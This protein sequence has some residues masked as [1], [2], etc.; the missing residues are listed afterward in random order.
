M[1]FISNQSLRLFNYTVPSFYWRE[2]PQNG[3]KE[4]N[5]TEIHLTT[6]SNRVAC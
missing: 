6:Q 5:R 4:K 2:E 1:L 3:A